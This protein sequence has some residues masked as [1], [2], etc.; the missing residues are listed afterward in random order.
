MPLLRIIS[1]ENLASLSN[2]MLNL[3]AIIQIVT[4]LKITETMSIRNSLK[5]NCNL[6]IKLLLSLYR[7]SD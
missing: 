4:H 1:V 3:Q 7:P 5:Q 6:N 2:T